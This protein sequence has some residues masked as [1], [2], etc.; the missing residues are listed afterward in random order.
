MVISG[1]GFRRCQHDHSVFI[2]KTATGIVVLV[3]YVDDILLTGSDIT[4]INETR[5]YMKKH[6][7]TKDM[8]KTKYFHALLLSQRK[9]VLD[10]LQDTGLLGC[11]PTNTPTEG[12]SD[13][14]NEECE[15]YKDVKQYR[16]LVG[17]LIYLTVTRPYISYSVGVLR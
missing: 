6:F 16:R 9:Y 10:L 13:L 1:I 12:E 17:K 15:E 5:E 8:G 7:V 11:K 3:V 4:A 14:W 2:R